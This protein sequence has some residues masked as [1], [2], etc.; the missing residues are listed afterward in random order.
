MRMFSKELRVIKYKTIVSAL[1]FSALF[2]LSGCSDSGGSAASSAE[3]AVVSRALYVDAPVE[4]VEY[5]C[6]AQKGITDRDGA[7]NYEV[8]HS[9][10][11]KIGAI[12]LREIAASKLQK[13]NVII[14]ETNPKIAQFLLTLDE[15][16][17]ENKIRINKILKKEF[18]TFKAENLLD[19]DPQK[20]LDQAV[21]SLSEKGINTQTIQVVSE[22]LA[23]KHIEN[24]FQ[25]YCSDDGFIL[26]EG[27]SGLGHCK[28]S[29][30]VDTI[31]PVITLNGATT[32]TLD[33]N[34]NFRDPG[35]SA[36]D[37]ADGDLSANIKVSSN[38]DTTQEGVYEIIYSVVDSAGN[39]TEITRKINIVQPGS[40]DTIAPEIRLL[41]NNPFYLSKGESYKEPGVVASDDRDGDITTF[42]V[43]TDNID[44]DK[45][46]SYTVSYYV[47][48]SAGNSITATREVRVELSVDT[49]PPVITLQG[50][51][52][53]T[54][55]VGET[56]VEPG[57]T[58]SDDRDETVKVM[59]SGT[60]DTSKEGTYKLIYSAE[61]AAGNQVTETRTVVVKAADK[62]SDPQSYIPQD[63]NLTDAMAV[64][65]LN[66]A[67]FG[68]TSELVAE[69]KQ[70]GVI[71]WLDDQLAMPYDEQKESILRKVIYRSINIAPQVYG[72]T[73]ADTNA[74]VDSSYVDEFL[75][76]DNGKYFNINNRNNAVSELYMNGTFIFDQ[77][78]RA[79]DQVRQRAAYALSQII[80][81]SQSNDRFFNDRGETLSYYYDL[82]LKHA[83]GNYGDLLYDISLSPTMATFLTFANNEKEY[84]D[85]DT[86]ATIL[87][88][89]NYGREIMQLFSIGLYE[90]NI[91]G[92]EKRV[93]DKRV[94][95]YE[96][97]DVNEMSK[98]FTGLTYAHSKWGKI[99][100]KGDST[101]PLE[102]YQDHHDTSEKHILGGTLPAGQTC[103]QDVKSAVNLLMNH[104]N[105]APFIAKKLILR[106]TKSNP[107][108][109][110]IKRVAEVFADTNGDLKETI[111]AVLLD[112]EIWENIKADKGVKIKEP[113]I[114]FTEVLRAMNFQPIPWTKYTHDDRVYRV[115][116]PGFLTDSLYNY[117]GEF[118]TNS[119]SVF[120]FYSDT[121]EPDND[122]FKI[123]GFVAPELAIYTAKYAVGL[124]NLIDTLAYEASVQR[125]VFYHRN[126]DNP[127]DYLPEKDPSRYKGWRTRTYM[128]IDFDEA[129]DVARNNGFGSN[130]TE[131]EGDTATREKVATALADYLSYKLLGRKLSDA[132][133]SMIIDKYKTSFF[134]DYKDNDKE[135]IIAKNDFTIYW[136]IPMMIDIIHTDAFMVQ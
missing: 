28:K 8:G 120:N 1:G 122:E 102:C 111:K 77:H 74:T 58:A 22:D 114:L 76:D 34:S 69:L 78:V 67:T 20:L 14:Q 83:F 27:G 18:E 33:I 128:Y 89:E 45:E 46:G 66:M 2:I 130:L 19:S 133:R 21:Q 23:T 25:K 3:E 108:T 81:A 52:Y 30:A 5:I 95:T 121:F 126:E 135:Y 10:T 17:Q 48:D 105:V 57:A 98:V 124:N 63:E 7:F 4:G 61:D 29:L 44:I 101:H 11:L 113:Y 103:E 97:K 93:N 75:E 118:P 84:I 35:A 26:A 90:L 88:D 107:T 132:R 60:V 104:S 16:P 40:A 136:V 54:L 51:S 100:L 91:D 43:S 6:G 73:P 87:P 13:K 106:L 117:L 116:N 134:R 49:T 123:R 42:V 47:E 110:Y 12:T 41:G 131:N 96:Q 32:I 64:K 50:D 56:F 37:N 125:R 109:A 39:K 112:E 24:S 36:T 127:Y 38:V 92:T 79:K 72:I 31:A 82:L 94:P 68:A 119:P 55:S 80:I 86:N 85:T 99:L 53:M 65:F 129:L 71:K 70:K 9:C 59:V 62:T 15:D 115:E